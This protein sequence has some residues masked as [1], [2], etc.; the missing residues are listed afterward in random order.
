[1]YCDHNKEYANYLMVDTT[2]SINWIMATLQVF[3]QYLQ[4]QYEKSELVI[5]MLLLLKFAQ[6]SNLLTLL[7]AC[8]LP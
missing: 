1:M 5:V 6:C 3:V 4:K 7:S 8:K 2:Y